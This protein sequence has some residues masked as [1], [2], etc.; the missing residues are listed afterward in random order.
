LPD[1]RHLFTRRD[2]GVVSSQGV[3]SA[4]LATE[5]RSVIR[6]EARFYDGSQAL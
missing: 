5:L 1:N 3:E 6:G 4:A 2:G